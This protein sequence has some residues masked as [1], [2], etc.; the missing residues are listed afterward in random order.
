M[1]TAAGG[2]EE[3]ERLR[4]RF[5]SPL[6]DF[7][8]VAL[9]LSLERDLELSLVRSGERGERCVTAWGERSRVDEEETG[10]RDLLV[11]KDAMVSLL[12]RTSLRSALISFIRISSC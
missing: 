8:W 6:G 2:D 1:L 3:G 5:A 10:G 9:T 12:L 11:F 7:F 4:L